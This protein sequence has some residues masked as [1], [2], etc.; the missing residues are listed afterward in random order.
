MLT[1]EQ[2]FALAN[3]LVDTVQRLLTWKPEE[4]TLNGTPVYEAPRTPAEK[5]FNIDA[6]LSDAVQAAFKTGPEDLV[7]PSPDVPD[8]PD[9]P[10]EET[11]F[12]LEPSEEGAP[13]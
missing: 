12:D 1:N 3:R 8:M 9:V 4:P 6:I 2:R 13:E 7:P 5:Q 10:D 11:L